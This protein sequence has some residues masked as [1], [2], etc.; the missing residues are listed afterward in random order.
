VIPN[1][2]VVT[3]SLVKKFKVLKIGLM[4]VRGIFFEV[5]AEELA[6]ERIREAKVNANI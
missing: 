3:T 1:L 4:F 2:D 5:D 6:K